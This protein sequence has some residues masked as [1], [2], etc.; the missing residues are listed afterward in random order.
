MPLSINQSNILFFDWKKLGTPRI[1]PGMDG[2]EAQTLPLCY[3]IPPLLLLGAKAMAIFCSIWLL[4][5]Q[6]ISFSRRSY[7]PPCTMALTW[8]DI[9]TT[10]QSPWGL[11]V[12]W[13]IRTQLNYWKVQNSC[14]ES[15][16][17]VPLTSPLSI[18][19]EL[20]DPLIL[21]VTSNVKTTMCCFAIV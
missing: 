3:A 1:K 11:S 21:S 14:D 18:E 15:C 19:P 12:T 20:L 7:L 10:T 2:W 13:I 16:S 9:S 6:K 17:F 5:H 4:W 8:I